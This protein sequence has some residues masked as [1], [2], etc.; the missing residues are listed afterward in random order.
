MATLIRIKRLF[1]EDPTDSIVVKSKRRRIEDEAAETSGDIFTPTILKRVAT[2]SSKEEHLEP[3]VLKELQKEFKKG[4]QLREQYKRLDKVGAHRD[5]ARRET[6]QRIKNKREEA[7]ASHRPTLSLNIITRIIPEDKGK[8]QQQKRGREGE[9]DEGANCAM[10]VKPEDKGKD[11]QQKRG[12]EEEKDEGANCAP[13][14]L[15]TVEDIKYYDTELS[16]KKVS[17]VIT[18]NG[19]PMETEKFVYDIYYWPHD[20]DW[21]KYVCDILISTHELSDDDDKYEDDDDEN[22]ENNWRNDY[23]EEDDSSDEDK[24]YVSQHL[25]RSHSRQFDSD[26][27]YDADEYE[28]ENFDEEGNLIDCGYNCETQKLKTYISALKL[29]SEDD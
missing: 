20:V 11:Q 1:N 6:K 27:S 23:P 7:H 16:S 14:P 18:C 24:D 13:P 2:V 4:W 12:R 21:M 19:V 9:K 29:H 8:D 22:D 3:E 5:A 17:D 26:E 15:S 10:K 25:H 28:E